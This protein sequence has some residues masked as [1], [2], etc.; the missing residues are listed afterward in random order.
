M[1]DRDSML[2]QRDIDELLAALAH[3]A[4]ERGCVLT[5]T[6]LVKFL[7]LLDLY[8]AQETAGRETATGWTWRFI[9]FGPWCAESSD[10]IA[11]A[12]RYGYIAAMSYEG[13][14]GD[15]DV[16]LFD[17]GRQLDE[18]EV[19]RVFDA[20][21]FHVGRGMSAAVR[22]YGDDTPS[23]LN[24]V[25]FHTGPMRDATP[26]AVLSFAGERKPDFSVLKPLVMKPLSKNKLAKAKE[27]LKT[28]VAR[29]RELRAATPAPSGPIDEHY[30]AFLAAVA[31]DETST[32][33]SGTAGIA[34]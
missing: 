26:S 24:H 34:R 18:H 30:E 27:A 23:L 13:R 16:Q 22:E 25:Y 19:G 3:R 6:R 9:H 8:W 1:P 10:A 12:E 20:M 7:Y 32:G 28:I 31:E 14:F 2:K 33:L 15:D 17:R 4:A 29:E 11:H 21:P 5:K